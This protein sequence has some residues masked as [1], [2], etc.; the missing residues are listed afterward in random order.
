MHIQLRV[1]LFEYG[2]PD[3]SPLHRVFNE[4]F[5][6]NES[7]LRYLFCSVNFL[8]DLDVAYINIRCVF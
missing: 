6:N 2:V 3:S 7:C 4:L 1:R 5:I 8:L